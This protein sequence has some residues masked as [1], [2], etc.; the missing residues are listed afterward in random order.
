MKKVS[1]LLL[2][3]KASQ[4]DDG[5]ADLKDSVDLSYDRIHKHQAPI[6]QSAYKRLHFNSSLS[7]TQ[8]S[9]FSDGFKSQKGG[10]SAC[11]RLIH[12][13]MQKSVA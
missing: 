3:D 6:D 11:R 9:R 2:E 10:T 1:A 7:T 5:Y 13:T 8:T 4:Q 12:G